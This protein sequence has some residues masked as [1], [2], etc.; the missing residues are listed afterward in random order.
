MLHANTIMLHVNTIILHVDKICPHIRLN[1]FDEREHNLSH[2]QPERLL[3]PV[4]FKISENKVL[5]MS[6]IQIY[7]S[8]QQMKCDNMTQNSEININILIGQSEDHPNNT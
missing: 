1:Y 6:F 3:V 8:L 5:S 4:L 7:S 2:R